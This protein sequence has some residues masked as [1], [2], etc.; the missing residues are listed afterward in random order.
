[1][2]VLIPDLKLFQQVFRKVNS[3]KYVRECTINYCY[4]LSELDTE[5]KCKKF[6]YDLLWLNEMSYLQRYREEP[7]PEMPDML[8][9]PNDAKKPDTLQFFK[10]LQCIEYNIE[11]ETIE[12]GY[13]GM[14]GVTIPEDK[15][16][17]YKLLKA[18][19]KDLS[20]TIIRELTKYEEKN[21][22][23]PV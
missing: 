5:S 8:E 6:V 10:F 19:L 20:N 1:M 3:F 4:P 23:E 9:F 15:K 13:D 21:W 2:S 17:S 22:C 18:A 12:R 16:S 7:K 11:I 14:S